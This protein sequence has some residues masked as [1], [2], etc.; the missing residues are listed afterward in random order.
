MGCMRPLRREIT[1][2]RTFDVVV[3]LGLLVILLP[4]LL[5][6]AV[7]QCIVLRSSRIF[8][9]QDRVGR[10]GE[11][12]KCMKFRTMIFN[13]DAM[14][15]EYLDR[16]PAARV[17]W[18][19]THKLRDDPRITSF[20]KYLRALSLDELPQLWNILQGDMSLV[21]P[22]PVTRLELDNW[23]SPLGAEADY[24]SVRPGLTGLWQTSGRSDT[25]YP[26]RVALDKR[27]VE[28]ISLR[29]DVRI[30]YRTF[31]VVVRRQGAW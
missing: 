23:Y 28:Q 31:W 1:L 25:S 11:R 14:L 24:M 22:R 4:V 20:G 8:Y 27:Y 13:A 16:N 10:G 29:T 7:V 19:S 18:M 5:L 15:Q 21:G 17:E 3:V 6:I 9:T 26:E 2:K 30:L 12:F